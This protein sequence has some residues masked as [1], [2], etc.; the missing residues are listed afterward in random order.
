MKI[1]DYIAICLCVVWVSIFFLVPLVPTEKGYW[2][3]LESWLAELIIPVSIYII[4]RYWQHRKHK[5]PKVEL[6]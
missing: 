5:K 4:F 2:Y 1:L 3:D 6:S